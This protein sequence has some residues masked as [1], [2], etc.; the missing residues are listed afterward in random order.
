VIRHAMM[1]RGTWHPLV[2]LMVAPMPVDPRNLAPEFVSLGMMLADYGARAASTWRED[3]I[4]R[5]NDRC[6]A[7]AQEDCQ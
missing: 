7:L 3:V 5:Y 1:Q 2:D 6:L 4:R